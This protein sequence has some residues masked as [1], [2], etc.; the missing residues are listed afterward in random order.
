MKKTLLSILI[1][2]VVACALEASQRSS[3]HKKKHPVS[4]LVSMRMPTDLDFQKLHGANKEKM[5]DLIRGFPADAYQLFSVPKNGFF[6]LDG[7]DDFIKN[8]LKKGETWEGN[9]QKLIHQYAK[10]GTTVLDVGAHIGTHTLT[11][12]HAVGNSGQVFAFEPQPKIFRELFLNM[13]VNN[14][15][16]VS[17]YWAGIGDREGIIELGPL[18]ETNEGGSGLYGGTGQEVQLLT[19]DSLNLTN[20]SLIKIDVEG[21]EE[22]VLAGARETIL[23][24][25]PVILIEIMGGHDFGQ[26]SRDARHQILHTIDKIEELGYKVTQL[27]RHDWIAIPSAATQ[28]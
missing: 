7:I 8:H 9:I 6:Y 2:L 5:I 12:A 28:I 13:A 1:C 15:K 14:L 27:W 21:M 25:R 18:N 16:N 22:Q 24:N 4:E 19:I 3:K 23:A 20:V 10:P 11:M 17:F 26:T